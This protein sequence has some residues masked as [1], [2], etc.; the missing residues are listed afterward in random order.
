MSITRILHNAEVVKHYDTLTL[1]QLWRK[2]ND[3]L[4]DDLR[5]FTTNTG[6][7][8]D[9]FELL[10]DRFQIEQFRVTFA[11]GHEELMNGEYPITV[12]EVG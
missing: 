6:R 11:N 9:A 1:S 10:S 8:L 4:A 12:T 5:V 7:Q 2:D 3:Y